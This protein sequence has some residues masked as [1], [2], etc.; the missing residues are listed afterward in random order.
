MS[1]KAKG[2]VHEP[3]KVHRTCLFFRILNRPEISESGPEI[4][5]GSEISESEPEIS[6]LREILKTNTNL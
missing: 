1:R 6:G 4:S 5:E 2:I 3:L